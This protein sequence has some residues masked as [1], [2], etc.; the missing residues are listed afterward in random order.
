MSVLYYLDASAWVKRYFAE[1]GSSWM[2]AL[3][4]KEATLAS[5]ALGQIKVAAALA[6][7]A[8][9]GISLLTLQQQLQTEWN[10]MLQFEMTSNLYELALLIAWE[11]KL[12]G[13]DAIHLAAAQQLREQAARRSLDFILVASDTELI[14]AAQE[15]NL[16]VTNPAELA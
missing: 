3:F 6:R 13:A 4:L 16:V 10:S 1:A 5:T 12:R 7:R 11:R 14:Q 9:P 8:R 15:S 2:H